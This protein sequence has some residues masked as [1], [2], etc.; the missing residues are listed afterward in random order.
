M[1]DIARLMQLGDVARGLIYMHDQGM[2]HGG[3][4]GVRF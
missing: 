1:T 4:K 3:L 2:V